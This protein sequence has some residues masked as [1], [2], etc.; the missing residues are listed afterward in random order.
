M[1][2]ALE[3]GPQ[4]M[5]SEETARFS[6]LRPQ[7]IKDL[8]ARVELGKD[9]LQMQMQKSLNYILNEQHLTSHLFP[10]ATAARQDQENHYQ[11]AWVRDLSMIGMALFDPLILKHYSQGERT[12]DRIRSSGARLING[13]LSLFGQEP[14][15]S[16]FE[17]EIVEDKDQWG[18]TY[19]H[20]VREA[21]PTHSKVDGKD[22]S[23][24]T[25]NQ[26]DSWGEF[27]IAAASGIKHGVVKLD[28]EQ[29]KTLGKIADYLVR[30]QVDKFKQFS[31][32]EW[33]EVYQPAPL[34][35]VSLC[36]MGLEEISP[37]LSE[38]TREAVRSEAKKLQIVV[39]NLYPNEYTVPNG[40]E[41]KTDMATLVAHSV[42]ALSRHSF[43]EYS[44][45]A[46]Q[47]LGNGEHPGKKRYRGDDYHKK[48]QEAIWPMGTI[49]EAKVCLELGKSQESPELREKGLSGLRKAK[50]V[51]DRYGY[52]PELLRV[53]DGVFVPSKNHLL[54]NEALMTQACSRALILV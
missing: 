16:G 48:D 20:L 40:H 24:P 11:D 32:W 33:G 47:E 14:W 38:K 46:D 3:R 29:K 54:W 45:I 26:P 6:Y 22:C 19:T 10:A 25:Q 17:Q 52:I 5:Q 34:S 50:M 18:R 27:L 51:Y 23:W 41:S 53:E 31:M 21:P 8:S 28:D 39:A 9:H 36:A 49:M 4:L 37:H 30:T 43:T 35:T 44:D 2:G 13:M 15:E 42:G 7:D 1:I 12:G